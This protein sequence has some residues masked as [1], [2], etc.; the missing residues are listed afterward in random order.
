MAHCLILHLELGFIA[1]SR[2]P[3]DLNRKMEIA[4]DVSTW[5]GVRIPPSALFTEPSARLSRVDSSVGQLVSLSFRNI[6]APSISQTYSKPSSTSSQVSWTVLATL[7][8]YS[9]FPKSISW[10]YL[11]VLLMFLWPRILM[12][13]RMSLVLAYS[14]VA[15]QCLK[16]WK[17]IW[18]SLGFWSFRARVFLWLS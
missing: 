18:S 3:N 9:S 12:T 14:V 4:G 7:E 16:V 13:C 5:G 6:L 10:V 1:L 2:V 11:S 8:T 17:V 15:F